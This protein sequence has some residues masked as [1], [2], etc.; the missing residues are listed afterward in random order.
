MV[1]EAIQNA[2]LL[3]VLTTHGTAPPTPTFLGI[4]LICLYTEQASIIQENDPSYSQ[5][6]NFV[7]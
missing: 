3:Y 7:E 2:N 5:K 4:R 1:Q 6:D